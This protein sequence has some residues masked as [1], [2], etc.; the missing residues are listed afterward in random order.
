MYQAVDNYA[1]TIQLV[2]DWSKTQE[3]CDS[4]VDDY[5]SMIQFVPESY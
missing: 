1:S 2:P 3:M 4:A 5:P